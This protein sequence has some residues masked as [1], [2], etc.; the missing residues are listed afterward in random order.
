MILISC[1][2]QSQSLMFSAFWRQ[3]LIKFYVKLN[4]F[5]CMIQETI[6]VITSFFSSENL[7]MRIGILPGPGPAQVW[8]ELR[9]LGLTGPN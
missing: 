1:L 5:S 6:N 7:Q 9:L 2:R 3:K 4:S 8:T